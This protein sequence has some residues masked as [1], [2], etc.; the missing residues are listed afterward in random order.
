MPS[1]TPLT[2]WTSL[3]SSA[4]EAATAQAPQVCFL[5]HSMQSGIALHSSALHC[6]AALLSEVTSPKLLWTPDSARIMSRYVSLLG[7]AVGVAMLAP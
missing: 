7:K 1:A 3:L 5:S 2:T 6:I 4:T